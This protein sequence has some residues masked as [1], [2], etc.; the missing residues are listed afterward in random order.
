MTG[1][2][3]V[4]VEDTVASSADLSSRSASPAV[5]EDALRASFDDDRAA[6]PRTELGR[7]RLHQLASEAEPDEPQ[8]TKGDKSLRP[9]DDPSGLHETLGQL[10]G[11]QGVVDGEST[12]LVS[13]LAS[14]LQH[15]QSQPEDEDGE[16]AVSVL[17]GAATNAPKNA[18]DLNLATSTLEAYRI[19]LA[20]MR[21]DYE[22]SESRRQDEVHAYSERVDALQAKLQFLS[23]EMAEAAKG[24]MATAPAGSLERKLA[25]QQEKIALLL[26][27]G[28]RLSGTELKHMSTIKRL[29]AKLHQEEKQLMEARQRAEKAESA[30]A[31]LAQR[32]KRAEAAEKNA[33]EKLKACSKQGKDLETLKADHETKDALVATLRA[34][35]NQ[36]KGQANEEDRKLQTAALEA[37]RRLVSE[38]RDDLSTARIEKELLQGRHQSEIRGLEVRIEQEKERARAAEAESRREQAVSPGNPPSVPS[39]IC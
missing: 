10:S 9:Q 6:A 7:S 1:K 13:E 38:L 35:L 18:H 32:V 4:R 23:N 31:D 22:I 21:T 11:P 19:Q 36:L 34:Q 14:P 30:V 27:E 29:R 37:E 8:G 2:D 25:Q 26:E 39:P 33:N 12:V 3:N 17:S 15:P 20:Q 28:E 5:S 16:E 24:R